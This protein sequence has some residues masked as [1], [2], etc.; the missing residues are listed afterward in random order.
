MALKV[1]S[2]MMLHHHYKL[3]MPYHETQLN[4]QIWYIDFMH[5]FIGTENTHKSSNIR[6]FIAIRFSTKI[7]FDFLNNTK[8][9]R[10]YLMA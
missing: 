8:E 9:P 4:L 2:Y 7:T 6:D 1:T 3:K 5:E 10:H